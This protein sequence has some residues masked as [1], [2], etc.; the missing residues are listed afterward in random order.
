MAGL[1][2]AICYAGPYHW[3]GGI[4][5]PLAAHLALDLAEFIH[6]SATRGDT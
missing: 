1:V 2:A 5:A 3:H 4:V 6:A